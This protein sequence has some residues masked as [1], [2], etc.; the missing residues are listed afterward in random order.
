M[1]LAAMTGYRISGTLHG[2]SM[3]SFYLDG[4]VPMALVMFLIDTATIALTG[5]RSSLMLLISITVLGAAM[6]FR[7]WLDS[8][9]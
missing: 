1:V 7:S 5:S 9:A 8:N 4:L 3:S 2:S 6:I